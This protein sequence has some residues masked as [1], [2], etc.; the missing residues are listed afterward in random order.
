MIIGCCGSGKSTLARA[1]HEKTDLPLIYLDQ[2]YWLPNWREST[3]EVWEVKVRGLTAG[4]Q[5]IIDGNY[6]GTMNIRLA[7]ADTIVYLDFPTWKCLYRVIKRI[8][9]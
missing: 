1:L 3:K 9:K 5:W 2:H 8:V 7:R 4:E 6:S